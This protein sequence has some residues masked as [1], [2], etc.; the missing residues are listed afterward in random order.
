MEV[1]TTHGKENNWCA[2][3]V[4]PA[5]VYK[6]GGR[7]AGGQEGRA[8]GGV[9]LGLLVQVGSPPFPLFHRMD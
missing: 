5:H 9:L 4:P 7:E 8:M 1:G 6:G 3:G 2:F